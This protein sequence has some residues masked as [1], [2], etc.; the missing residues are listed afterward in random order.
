MSAQHFSRSVAVNTRL[1]G[2]KVR[3]NGESSFDRAVLENLGHDVGLS[4]E[5]IGATA[6]VKILRPSRAVPA[7]VLALGRTVRV[8]EVLRVLE[9]VER[10]LTPDGQGFL[11]PGT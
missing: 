2:Q 6:I 4:G 10:L 3:V 9:S 1:V 5:A 8:I 11:D 7:R